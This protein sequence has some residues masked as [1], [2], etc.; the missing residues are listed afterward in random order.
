MELRPVD[1]DATVEPGEPGS[2]SSTEAGRR[3]SLAEVFGVALRLG[4]TS[5]GGPIA[6]LGYFRDEYVERRKWVDEATYADLVAVSQSLPGPSSSMLGMSIGT[7]RAGLP[8]GLAAWLGFTLPS[9]VMLVLFG[10]GADYIGADADGWLHGLKVVAVAVVALAVW[11]MARS[12]AFDRPRGTLAIAA[13]IV[14]L[15]WHTPLAQFVAIIGGGLVG[16][17]L[18]REQAEVTTSDARIALGRRTVI[19]CGG[20]FSVLLI[21]LPI[22]RHS[23]DNQAVNVT[24]GFFRSGALVFGGGHVVL[25]LLDSEVVD[26]GWVPQ[27]KFLAGYGAAQAVPGPLFTFSAYLGTVMEPEPNGVPGAAL[28]LVAIFLPGYLLMMGALPL[29]Q[30]ARSRVGVRAAMAG[31]NAAVVGI[32]LAALYDPVATSAI[33]KSSDFALALAA[34]AALAVWK[35]PPWLVVIVAAAT[36]ALI[37]AF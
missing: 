18:L 17:L 12:L 7:L 11:S 28:A 6:H 9:A 33:E 14:M 22:L 37:G 27:D 31:V 25:P 13:A 4:L 20:L 5:F 32:L 29:W 30:G 15:S 24:D 36:G 16:W 26:H 8:G 3:G 21:G 2:P 35:L 23:V 19:V 1:V 34:F 10:F